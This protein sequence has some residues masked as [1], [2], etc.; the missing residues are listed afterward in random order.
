[1]RTGFVW[2]LKLLAGHP[3]LT[4]PTEENVRTWKFADHT[5]ARFL[6]TYLDVDQGHHKRDP[7]TKCA[8]RLEFASKVTVS[9]NFSFP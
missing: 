7:A 2:L 5:P 6:V 4:P 9:T 3:V 1:M 8:A